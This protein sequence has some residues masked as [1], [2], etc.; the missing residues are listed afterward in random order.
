[1]RASNR[2]FVDGL[3]YCYRHGDGME[4]QYIHFH[5]WLSCI[6]F[7]LPLIFPGISFSV[8]FSSSSILSFLTFYS[9]TVFLAS[10]FSSLFVSATFFFLFSPFLNASFLLQCHDAHKYAFGFLGFR[11]VNQGTGNNFG[12]NLFWS[13]HTIF[14]CT[15]TDNVF[16]NAVKSDR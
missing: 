10:P 4:I 13:L 8:H 11:E 1:M 9:F 12:D 2:T 16:Q 3:A 7:I 15:L 5:I 14:F 6:F